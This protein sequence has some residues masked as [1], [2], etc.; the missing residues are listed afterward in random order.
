M[1]AC[2]L[3]HTKPV[4]VVADDTDILILLQHHFRPAEH[5]S[6]YLQTSSKLISI[7]IIKR[8][9]DPVLS[10]SLLFIHALS[11]C[12]T[13]SGS[14]CIGK[15]SAMGKYVD[16]KVASQIFMLPNKDH[17]EG[18]QAGNEAL[19][20]IYACKQGTDLN[21]ERA[22]K[23]SEKVESTSRCVLLSGFPQLQMPPNFTA[24]GSTTRCKFGKVTRWRP[25]NGAG[26]NA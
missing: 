21:L 7:E 18:E 23:L 6:V 3:A 14:Y 2:A 5:K 25:L 9:I 1:S 4:V 26:R 20:I 11:G 19:A 16:L 10:K 17:N 24:G 13:T 12:D 15:I 8:S 22:S